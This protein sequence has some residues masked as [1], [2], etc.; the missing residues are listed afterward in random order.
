MSWDIIVQ[1]LPPGVRHVSE[2]APDFRPGPI[3]PDRATVIAR[4]LDVFPDADF[5]DS[6]WGDCSGDGW[7]IEFNM[8]D[9]DEPY[10]G[11]V[12]HVYGGGGAAPAIANLLDHLAL[13]AIDIGSPTGIFDREGARASFLEWQKYRDHALGNRP[14]NA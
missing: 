4:I 5:S 1:D 6:A 2:I 13:P 7:S 9:P 12:M 10:M 14:P 11:F 3:A 8:G